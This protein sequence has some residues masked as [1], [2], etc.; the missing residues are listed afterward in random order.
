MWV[1]GAD[2]QL[3]LHLAVKCA[4][5]ADVVALLLRACPDAAARRNADGQLP[6]HVAEECGASASV[7]GALLDAHPAAAAQRN[8]FGKFPVHL[9]LRRSSAERFVLSTRRD[10]AM[11][12]PASQRAARALLGASST[13]ITARAWPWETEYV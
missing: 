8:S 13:E 10:G 2:G 5:P 1:A 7:V 12:R 11:H 3:P 9:L 6:L 4:A